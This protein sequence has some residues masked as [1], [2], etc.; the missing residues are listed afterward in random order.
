MAEIGRDDRLGQ[1]PTFQFREC[2][3]I[4]PPG[5][6]VAFVYVFSFW[7]FWRSPDCLFWVFIGPADS[8]AQDSSYMWNPEGCSSYF[9]FYKPKCKQT[10][11][12]STFQLFSWYN[13]PFTG[14]LL[15][16]IVFRTIRPN[17]RHFNHYFVTLGFA[18]NGWNVPVNPKTK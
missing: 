8:L 5:G 7:P 1:K 6:A 2:C 11:R 17:C 4:W 18:E 12:A 15:S 10:C 16:Q 3:C 9:S 14:K 13:S